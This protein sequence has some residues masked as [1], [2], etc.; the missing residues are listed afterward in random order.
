MMNIPAVFW[1]VPVASARSIAR[2]TGHGVVL[3]LPDDGSR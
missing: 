2:G 1:L 3:L